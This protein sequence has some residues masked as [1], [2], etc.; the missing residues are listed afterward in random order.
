MVDEGR[1]EGRVEEGVREGG[2]GVVR[3]VW[4]EMMAQ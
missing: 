3:N 4:E 1:E 2:E